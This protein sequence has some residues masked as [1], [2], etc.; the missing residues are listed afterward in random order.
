VYEFPLEVPHD[1]SWSVAP[2]AN[3]SSYHY[4]PDDDWTKEEKDDLFSLS[5]DYDLR[6]PVI[7]D[8]YNFFG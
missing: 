3:I 5:N 6:F 8:Q 4:F 2:A 1:S 7:S